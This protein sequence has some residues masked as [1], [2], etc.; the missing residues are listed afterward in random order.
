MG[1]EC[2]AM[3]RST[4]LLPLL[5][6]TACNEGGTPVVMP[7]GYES[8]AVGRAFPDVRAERPKARLVKEGSDVYLKEVNAPPMFAQ[9]QI[10]FHD[11]S[12]GPAPAEDALKVNRA[13]FTTLSDDAI[14]AAARQAARATDVQLSS[15]QEAQS[16]R[17]DKVKAVLDDSYGKPASCDPQRLS[18]TWEKPDLQVRLY[19][20]DAADPAGKPV[21][22]A[23]RQVLRR[24][25]AADLPQPPPIVLTPEQKDEGA[26]KPLVDASGLRFEAPEPI[27]VPEEFL[28]NP[29]G[30]PAVPALQMPEPTLPRFGGPL[31]RTPPVDAPPAEGEAR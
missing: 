16:A 24:K 23:L 10:W 12:Q 11:A 15:M 2:D 5:V 7:A 6:L 31:P 17:F 27:K 22:V 4:I 8:A 19:T 21:P 25:E 18:C 9:A 13:V 29:S 1:I 26:P 14:Q 3:R 20:I 28:K 30:R